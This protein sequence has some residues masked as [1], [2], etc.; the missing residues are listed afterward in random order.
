MEEDFFFFVFFDFFLGF[1]DTPEEELACES[2]VAVLE[3]ESEESF[4]ST[5]SIHFS[6]TLSCG[7]C[8]L[9]KSNSLSS[10]EIL[11]AVV[12]KGLFMFKALGKAGP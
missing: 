5:F 9:N 8:L 6:V 12:S 4:L 3:S 7:L 11:R 2:S 10:I 1:A